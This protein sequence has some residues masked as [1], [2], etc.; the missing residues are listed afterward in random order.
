LA[1]WYL[2]V[3]CSL[4]VL[5]LRLKNFPDSFDRDERKISWWR[6][7]SCTDLSQLLSESRPMDSRSDSA[8]LW[9]KCW[10]CGETI[11]GS[12]SCKEYL[13]VTWS[14]KLFSF[15]STA[16]TWVCPYLTPLRNFQ[17]VHN[18]HA[19]FFI[20]EKLLLVLTLQYTISEILFAV[21]PGICS[22]ISERPEVILKEDNSVLSSWRRVKD[23]ICDYPC[24]TFLC[25]R[26]L[27]SSLI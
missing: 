1:F 20:D 23:H 15:F 27:K 2:L 9:Y 6:L 17:K 8:L 14:H 7:A 21:I 13:V 25:L 19:T 16:S 12:H 18:N 3:V 22:M 11:K 26:I 10:N 24:D 5:F 4:L